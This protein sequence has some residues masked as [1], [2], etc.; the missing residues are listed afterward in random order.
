MDMCPDFGRNGGSFCYTRL[1]DPNPSP[2]EAG[3]H[4]VASPRRRPCPGSP[5][6]L[7]GRFISFPVGW[8]GAK[9]AGSGA[10]ARVVAFSEAGGR[11]LRAVPA[12]FEASGPEH[13]A[14]DAEMAAPELRRARSA[15]LSVPAEAKSSF[16]VFPPPHRK[17][18]GSRGAGENVG[19]STLSRF[20]LDV[21]STCMGLDLWQARHP[22]PLIVSHARATCGSE[23]LPGLCACRLPA[24]KWVAQSKV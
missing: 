11:A 8:R 1:Q 23:P 10:G 7:P 21:E 16:S 5:D 9:G 13:C 6:R 2:S 24:L 14:S 20:Y 22:G 17:S 18:A 19:S 12:G 3:E 15:T 4:W